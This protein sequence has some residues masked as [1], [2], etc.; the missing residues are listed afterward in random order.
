MRAFLAT[1]QPEKFAD[2]ILTHDVL[3]ANLVL[4]LDGTSGY[5][6]G[7]EEAKALWADL[8]N[9]EDAPEGLCLITGETAPIARLHPAI[10][11][12]WGG[13]SSGG[14]IISFNKES[15]TSFGKEQGANAPVSEKSAFAYTSALNY[16][17][18]SDKHSLR[19]G[20]ASTVFWA[21]AESVEQATPPP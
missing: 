8:L 20:D 16:L 3:N 13:Q 21:E 10:K 1:W 2:S 5:I 6:H 18:R 11:G 19:I 4:K 15:F 12:V 17:L 14:S 7:R 9:T